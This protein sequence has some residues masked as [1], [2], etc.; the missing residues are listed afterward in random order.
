VAK[1]AAAASADWNQSRTLVVANKCDLMTPPETL[2]GELLTISATTGAGVS[3][4]IVAMAQQLVPHAPPVESAVP[5]TDRQVD[6]LRELLGRCQSAE[7]DSAEDSLEQLLS[8][9]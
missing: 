4:L 3:S 1:Q 8:G 9:D 7:V 5:F 2:D 6:L